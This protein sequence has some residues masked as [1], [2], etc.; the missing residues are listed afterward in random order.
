MPRTT[1]VRSIL[2]LIV[3]PLAA[4]G[5][6]SGSASAAAPLPLTGRTVVLDPGHNGGNSTHPE[7]ANAL[8]YAGNGIY[9]P[10]NTSGT[11]TNAG[12]SEHAYTWDV[13]NRTAAILRARG[14]TVVLTRSDDTGV[15]PCVN[16]R[17]RIGN[18]NVADAVVSIHA[19][20]NLGTGARGFH[21]I[22]PAWSG[23]PAGVRSASAVLGATLRTTFRSTTGIPYA[24]Y[25]AGGDALDYR[26]DLGGLNLSSRPVVFIETGNMRNSTDAANLS[27][28]TGRQKIAQGIASGISL[29]LER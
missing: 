25:I 8:T 29:Y 13:A 2:L 10:C 19:D 22:M 15:G 7:I 28:A 5:A 23:T 3:V 27:S 18:Q 12:Y 9:K 26:G 14:A 24:N 6:V 4:L 11:A 21:L 1:I 16:V 20:G 17:A